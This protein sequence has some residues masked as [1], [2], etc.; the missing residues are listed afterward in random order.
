MTSPTGTPPLGV[1]VPG[2]F[3]LQEASMLRS[4]S[5]GITS[6]HSSPCVP[7]N[8]EWNTDEHVSV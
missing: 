8:P 3:T 5:P 1:H 4:C 2:S 7:T 6:P